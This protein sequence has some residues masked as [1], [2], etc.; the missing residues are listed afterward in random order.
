[1]SHS[2][3]KLSILF[4]G[5]VVLIFLNRMVNDAFAPLSIHLSVIG[6]LAIFP[7]LYLPLGQGFLCVILIGLFWDTPLPYSAL[8]FLLLDFTIIAFIKHRIRRQ[9]YLQCSVIALIG[10]FFIL[11]FLALFNSKSSFFHFN[12]WLRI[13]TDILLSEIMILICCYWFF[14]FQKTL[15]DTFVKNKEEEEFL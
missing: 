8:P 1:M 13:F 6:L 7:A 10:N 3:I 9:D 11:L 4:L 12:Y 2:I 15:L 14:N 5:A